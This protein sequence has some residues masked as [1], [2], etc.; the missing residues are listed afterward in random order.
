M[1]DD[2]IKMFRGERGE[3]SIEMIAVALNITTKRVFELQKEYT[4]TGTIKV[5]DIN[6]HSANYLRRKA[7]QSQIISNAIRSDPSMPLK[8]IQKKL[9]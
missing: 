1:R 9:E 7:I 5:T 6:R 8:A 3:L 2:L 4:K